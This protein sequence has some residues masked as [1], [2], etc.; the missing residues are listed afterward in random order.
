[1][2][3]TSSSHDIK[4][5]MGAITKRQSTIPFTRST[6][7]NANKVVVLPAPGTEKLAPCL[8]ENNFNTFCSCLSVS[9]L[10]KLD[11]FSALNNSS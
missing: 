7:C 4:A 6:E 2:S 11:A 9:F 1:M 5:F 10:E 3:V 8:R